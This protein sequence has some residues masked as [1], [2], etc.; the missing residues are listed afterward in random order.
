MKIKSPT[1]GQQ[2]ALKAWKTRRANTKTL[3]AKRSKAS[4]K[5]WRTRHANGN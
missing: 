1:K 3:A 4:Q 5:A 2:A